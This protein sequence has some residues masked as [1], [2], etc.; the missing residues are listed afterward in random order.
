MR[1]LHLTS[2]LPYHP[3]GPGGATRQYFL[4]KRLVERGASVRSI[5]PT[6]NDRLDES[7]A[8]TICGD[9][10]ID[11]IPVVRNPDRFAE[12]IVASRRDP[13]VVRDGLTAPWLAWRASVFWPYVHETVDRIVREW[14]PHLV[15]IEH[16]QLAHWG[17]RLPAGLPRVLM[18]HNASWEYY[19]SRAASASS[20][21]RRYM[22]QLE[23]RR[24]VRHARRY[25]PTFQAVVATSDEDATAVRSVYAGPIYVV[26]NGADCSS[27]AGTPLPPTDE[28][29]G[30]VGTLYYPPNVEGLE[31]FCDEVWPRIIAHRPR[32]VFD[33]I[34]RSP[35]SAVLSLQRHAGVTVVGPVPDVVPY[36]SRSAVMIAP[37]LAGGG[38]KLKV[39]EAFAAGRPLV[40]TGV[41]AEG[42]AA[43]S[44]QH[45]L[46]ADDPKTF[47]AAID[48]LL[49]DHALCVRIG[50]AARELANSTYD[51]PHQGDLLFDALRA[52]LS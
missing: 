46:Q 6:T 18:T 35:N 50:A 11:L 37:L 47:A 12:A 16:D 51:W 3:A 19:A 15:L 39:I 25:F 43:V 30:F 2:E 8:V 14:Q 34:G 7:S 44:S 36:V 31:W 23:T 42:I 26:P 38:T 41:A 9:A 40:A 21:A 22:L 45:F 49:D 20:T 4:L 29:V 32:A 10:G 28:R 27:L 13:R 24:F 52:T 17:H 33:I 5:V 48:R 1:I